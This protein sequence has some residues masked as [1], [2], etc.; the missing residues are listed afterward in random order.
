MRLRFAG[1][2]VDLEARRVCRGRDDV[3][4]SPK[5]FDTLRILIENRP[6]AV[7]KEALLARVW[8]DTIVSEGSL[9]RVISEL[10][11]ALDD[12]ARQQIRTVHTYGYAFAADVE[13]ETASHERAG[14][15]VTGTLLLVS[16]TRTV[17]LGEGEHV[18]GRDPACGIPIDS[19][20]VS[21]RHARIVSDARGAT[22]EDLGSK[23][24]TFVGDER[25]AGPRLLRDG[26][27]L[28]FGRVRFVFRVVTVSPPTQTDSG[29]RG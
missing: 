18:V 9:A 21:W 13:F 24:G 15:P 25:V 17:V 7:S 27:E 29:S 11:S 23:N 4:L 3:H 22:I 19:P 20:K 28:R 14:M 6:G 12:A 10:R 2:T 5:A 26:D 1:C 16:G 8:S